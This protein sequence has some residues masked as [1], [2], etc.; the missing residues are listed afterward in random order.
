[1][2][3]IC[4]LYLM[5]RAEQNYPTLHGGVCPHY[6]VD[7]MRL[8]LHDEQMT[9]GILGGSFHQEGPCS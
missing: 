4:I 2:G 3:I 9:R 6:R 8:M 7:E 1:M 5:L